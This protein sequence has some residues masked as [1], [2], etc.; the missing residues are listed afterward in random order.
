MLPGILDNQEVS[1]RQRTMTVKEVAEALGTAESTVRNKVAEMFPTSVKNGKATNL[2][3]E[4]ITAI[5]RAIVPRDLTLKSKLESSVTDLE[6]EMKA[7]EVMAWQMRK[8]QEMR[9]R[10][11]IAEPKAEIADRLCIAVNG[12]TLFDFAKT[13]G[14][15]PKK[16]YPKLAEMGIIY[17]TSNGDWVPTQDLINQGYFLARIKPIPQGAVVVSHTTTIITGKGEAWLVGSLM[18]GRLDEKQLSPIE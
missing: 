11:T 2:T 4:Q 15:G 8:I 7:V 17:R 6:M 10:L 13:I 9:E 3:E 5:K 14:E 1:A 12:M 16:I 18:I